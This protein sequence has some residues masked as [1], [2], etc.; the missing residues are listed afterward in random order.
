MSQ[1]VSCFMAISVSLTLDCHLENVDCKNDQVGKWLIQY[2]SISAT[3]KPIQHWLVSNIIIYIGQHWSFLK[4]IFYI[5]LGFP[6]CKY[7]AFIRHALFLALDQCCGKPECLS[8][9]SQDKVF[10]C[11]GLIY[12]SRG[13]FGGSWITRSLTQ[14]C[15]ALSEHQR[16]V[17]RFTSAFSELLLG[18]FLHPVSGRNCFRAISSLA[19]LFTT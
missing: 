8:A 16:L 5:N 11:L 19:S 15:L 2:R 12:I 18:R 17:L 1:W 7:S 14:E 9:D 4:I 6:H 3:E 13:Y 10:L